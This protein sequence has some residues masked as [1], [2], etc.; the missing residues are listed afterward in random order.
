MRVQAI[1]EQAIKD[2]K[3]SVKK[4]LTIVVGLTAVVVVLVLTYKRLQPKVLN[5]FKSRKPRYRDLR[6]QI[7]NKEIDYNK[8]IEMMAEAQESYDDKAGIWI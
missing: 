8:Y 4:K 2:S 7:L 6:K 1:K 3:V 5:Y